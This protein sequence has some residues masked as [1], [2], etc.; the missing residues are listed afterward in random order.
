MLL[1]AGMYALRVPR[2]ELPVAAAGEP[3]WNHAQG[4]QLPEGLQL[5]EGDSPKTADYKQRQ[6]ERYL[7]NRFAL[8]MLQQTGHLLGG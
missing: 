7:A 8:D 6:Q 5:N 4:S 3:A 2:S 1:S